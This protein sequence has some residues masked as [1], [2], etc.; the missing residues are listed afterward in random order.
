MNLNRVITG[1]CVE[2]MRSFPDESIGMILTSPPYNVG[3]NYEGFD[4]NLTEEEFKEFN[5]RWL[6]EA[7]RVAYETA[8]IYVIVSDKMLWWFRGMAEEIGWKYVQ[9]LIWCKP[10]FLGRAGMITA[11]WNLMTENILLFRKGKRTSMQAGGLRV[12]THNWFVETSPQSNYRDGR[13]HPAQLPFPL[14]WKIISRTPGEPVLDPFAGSG[15]VL[16]AA[17]SL[18]RSYIGIELVQEVAEKARQFIDDIY[19]VNNQHQG[20]FEL[21]QE[22][23]LE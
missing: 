16:R 22:N 15:Q 17:K 9:L 20:M 1:D 14:C 10:N 8:R 5:R 6:E 23:H 11:D 3:L 13:H 19:F 18:N 12:T 21:L 2:V 7:Y 4:D